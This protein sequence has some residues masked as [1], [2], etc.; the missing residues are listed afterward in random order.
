MLMLILMQIDTDADA[1]TLSKTVAHA[2]QEE[3]TQKYSEVLQSTV[4]SKDSSMKWEV[5]EIKEQNRIPLANLS[6]GQLLNQQSFYQ[7]TLLSD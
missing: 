1:D 5:E 6:V 7:T 2:M 4:H 3:S